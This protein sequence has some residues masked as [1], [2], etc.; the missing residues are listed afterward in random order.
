MFF[1]PGEAVAKKFLFLVTEISSSMSAIYVLSIFFVSQTHVIT[2]FSINF[3]CDAG[4]GSLR[5]M[6]DRFN[7]RPR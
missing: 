7:T 6:I 2:G 1:T 5:K 4:L 3:K